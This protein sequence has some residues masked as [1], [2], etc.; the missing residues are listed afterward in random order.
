MSKKCQ[1]EK[2]REFTSPYTCGLYK[3]EM[4][5]DQMRELVTELTE[6]EKKSPYANIYYEFLD[7]KTPE[8][9]A[10]YAAPLKPE[11]MFMPADCGKIMIEHRGE[12]PEYGYGVLE[13]GVGYAAIRV[14]QTDVN[15]DM[16]REYREYYAHDTQNRDIFYKT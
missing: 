7:E 16:I 13:N 8:Q 9:K 15:D 4:T 3:D 11:Q 1:Y 6:E 14:D 2:K 5:L 10:A 12:Y